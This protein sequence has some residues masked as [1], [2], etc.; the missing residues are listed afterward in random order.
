[1]SDLPRMAFFSPLNPQK[2]GISDYSEELLPQLAQFFSIDLYLDDFTP[3][4]PDIRDNFPCYDISEF[5]PRNANQPYAV[6]LYHIGN[7][8]YHFRMLKNFMQHGGV[9]VLHD[10]MIHNLI[11]NHVGEDKWNNYFTEVRYCH[12]EEYLQYAKDTRAGKNS[13][14]YY[15][16]PMNKRVVEHSEGV[17]VHNLYVERR[18]RK[19]NPWI[20]IT[21]IPHHGTLNL[22]DQAEDTLLLRQRLGLPTD[23]LVLAS[24][25]MVQPFKRND[26]I[27]RVFARLKQRH[28]GIIYVMAGEPDSSFPILEQIRELRLEDSVR[29]TGFLEFSDLIAHMQTCDIV[30]NLRFPTTGETSGS[31]IRALGCG[32]PVVVSDVGSYREFPDNCTIKVPVD[33]HEEEVL[34]AYLDELISNEP[35][36][37]KMADAAAE[38][39]RRELPVEKTAGEYAN[40][41]YSLIKRRERRGAQDHI[42]NTLR[43]GCTEL[44]I[45]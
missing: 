26:V 35:L 25:G 14:D 7:N 13:P 44:A 8:P 43:Q 39:V 18:L 34:E 31:L 16:F 38:F 21:R 30:L 12:G 33:E 9:I 24:F 27:L 22:T 23:K 15:N 1:M 36:R 45:T 40:F 11:I 5:A 29:I 3:T 32:K 20:P 42:I 17:I 4:N 41:I 6:S 2:S 37:R 19:N 28:Q 10:Y